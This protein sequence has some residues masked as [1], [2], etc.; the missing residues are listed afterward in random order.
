MLDLGNIPNITFLSSAGATPLS[1]TGSL[2]RIAGRAGYLMSRFHPGSRLG[3]INRTG[4]DLVLDWLAALMAGMVPTILHYPTAKQNRQVWAASIRHLAESCRLAG[5]IVEP[6]LAVPGLPA[7]CQLLPSGDQRSVGGCD[8]AIAAGQ[9]IQMSSGTTGHRKPI[10]YSLTD[11]EAHVASYN[12][13]MLMGRDDVVVSWLP[14]YHDMGFIACFLMPMLVGAPLVLIDPID[15]VQDTPLLY[16]AIE[17]YNGTICYMPNF[18]FEVMARV[19]DGRNFHSMRKWVSCAEPVS[20]TTARRFLKV[21]RTDEEAF[22][23][24]YAM[25]ENVFA[26][27]QSNGLELV[28]LD[29]RE[30]V[31]CGRPIADTIVK[32]VDDEICI[33]SPTSI[34]AYLD[35]ARIADGEGYYGSGDVGRMTDRGLVVLG[36]KR[37]ILVQAGVKHLL[38]DLDLTLNELFP[39]IRGRACSLAAWSEREGT[40]HPLFLVERQHFFDRGDLPE[41]SEAMRSSTS[42]GHFEMEF[43]PP[44]FVSKT[45]SGKIN[46]ADTLKHWQ[47]VQRARTE[48]TGR[49]LSGLKSDVMRY[50]SAFPLDAPVDEL[51]DSLGTTILQMILSDYGL[52][53]DPTATLAQVLELAKKRD[54][55]APH[56]ADLVPSVS[57][58]SCADGRHWSW[59]D[60]AFLQ[61]AETLLGCPVHFQHICTPPVPVLLSDLVFREYF[62]PG[63]EEYAIVASLLARIHHASMLVFDDIAELGFGSGVFPVLSHRLERDPAADLFCVRWQRYASNHD[64]LA[65]TLADTRPLN[66]NMREEGFRLLRRYLDIPLF[67]FAV[68]E[69]HQEFTQTWEH[70]DIIPGNSLDVQQR[71]D[72]DRLRASLLAF[73]ERNAAALP[74]RLGPTVSSYRN[75]DLP[76]F[77][78]GYINA[79]NLDQILQRYDSFAVIGPPASV[80]YIRHRASELGK[81]VSYLPH[82]NRN[83]VDGVL[84]LDACQGDCILITGA[85]GAFR[86][87][88]KPIFQ[89]MGAYPGEQPD[90]LPE[91][92]AHL[93]WAFQGE[94]PRDTAQSFYKY[95]DVA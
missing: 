66:K 31:S 16:R 6:E 24:C 67:R 21:T 59:M 11:I 68:L 43:V 74:R 46:R 12:R 8:M 2:D 63:G 40:E 5:V 28:E 55:A 47:A 52:A 83:P 80:P 44:F 14:L 91:D 62:L 26:V 23:A 75:S 45:S 93:R 58:V 57:I 82:W 13:L 84:E 90:N 35:G 73:I 69:T 72:P 7:S 79:D 48:F 30:A 53:Y 49:P 54:A 88:Q 60:D 89:V 65:V 20:A 64:A 18:G 87:S 41:M 3:L 34:I 19:A 37:D 71:A 9:I 38:S 61:Q 70:R 92:L 17:R 81:P 77:C 51:L 29:G 15:W 25:A 4:P 94:P 1:I 27:T 32:V 76:H 39:E 78:C 85:W 22:A 10:A 86:G 56:Q 50:F 42:L 33:R 95:W 36:R